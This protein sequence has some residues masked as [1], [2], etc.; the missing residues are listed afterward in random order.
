MAKNRDGSGS[1]RKPPSKKVLK[2]AGLILAGEATTITQAAE[3]VGITRET[4]SRNLKRPDV[5]DA[6]RQMVSNRMKTVGV[7]KAMNTLETLIE[8]SA[9]DY[10]KL[11]ASKYALGSAGV[12]PT[13]DPSRGNGGLV[14]Q[15][16]LPASM[17]APGG[18]GPVIEHE[19]QAVIQTGVDSD[20]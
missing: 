7:L 20:E 14:V 11:D 13:A 1:E 15:I 3:L 12:K 17:G 6:I 4:L 18:R 5:T 8:G 2:A 19:S 10:V 9:S 16:N